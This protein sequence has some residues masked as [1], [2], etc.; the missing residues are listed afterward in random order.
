MRSRILPLVSL[1]LA[2]CT[3]RIGETPLGPGGS[4]AD[5]GATAGGDGGAVT[6]HFVASLTGARRLS[7]AE[8]QNSMHD[9]FG[10]DSSALG[11]LSEDSYTPYDNS[12]RTQM[13]SSALIDSLAAMADDVAT[14]T[15]ADAQKRGRIMSCTPTGPG[16]AACFRTIISTVG[17]RAFR[18]PLTEAEIVDYLSLQA[19]A[20][21]DNP[22]VPKSFDTAVSLLL[23]AILQDPEFLYRIEAGTPGPEADVVTLSHFELAT[24]LSYL[25]LGTGPD[26]ALI[27][28]AEAS[29]LDEAGLTAAANRLLADPRAKDQLHRFHSM[30][31]GYRAIPG[32]AQLVQAFQRE[33][34]ALLDRV[35]FEDKRSYLDVFRSD[36][37][38]V[39]D[40]LADN[41][42]L[43]HPS[44]GMGWVTYPADS[45]RAG[46]LSH[47]TVLAAFSK[48]T[49]TSPTQRGILVKNR[50]LCQTIA[51]PPPTVMADKP[52]GE[53]T[54]ACKKDR[55]LTHEQVQSCANCHGQIDPIGFGLENFDVAGRFRTHDDGK[56]EC[57]IDGAG[58][59]PGFGTFSGPAELSQKLIDTN[60]L[61]ACALQQWMTFAI[62]HPLDDAD[63]L[64]LDQLLQ[65]FRADDH[66]LDQLMLEYIKHPA[67]RLAKKEAL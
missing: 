6:G 46:L 50:L 42:G 40:F 47:G 15:L 21:E 34:S 65:S 16:D 23:Q 13:A 24:R 4:G 28:D 59:L 31:L 39:D 20:T 63:R 2:S 48:F 14:R 32:T 1:L 5:G 29:R 36:Q 55:Y 45:H 44:G 60:T 54:T 53:G 22:Y 7:R 26:D 9:L 3:A 61:D 12:Y 11:H 51:P 62:G 57:V 64:Q 66:K 10:D 27:A 38:Y 17:R 19:Y 58:T 30:W 35:I 25:L 33:T 49:D 37:T 41:Y 52:P 8:L 18:R 56:P 67:F 43:P